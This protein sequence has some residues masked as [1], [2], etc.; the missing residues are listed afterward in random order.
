MSFVRPEKILMLYFM[1]RQSQY[2]NGRALIRP[3]VGLSA[4][5]YLHLYG[6]WSH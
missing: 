1:A 6:S 3:L 2:S 4:N 5:F